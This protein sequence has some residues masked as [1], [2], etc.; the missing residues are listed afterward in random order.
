MGR[1]WKSLTG[2]WET[3]ACSRS[4]WDGWRILWCARLE[5]TDGIARDGLNGGR[6]EEKN[7]KKRGKVIKPK[8]QKIAKRT[9]RGCSKA[10]GRV[11][12]S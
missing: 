10:I 2:H 1:P 5:S 6:D 8:K 4:V 3:R 11:A 12:G 7:E 9:G